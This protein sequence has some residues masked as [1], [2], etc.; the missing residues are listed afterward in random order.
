MKNG[1]KTTQMYKSNVSSQQNWAI[2]SKVLHLW[3]L[4]PRNTNL[5][6]ILGKQEKNPE[7]C[8]KYK[9]R[10][11]ASITQKPMATERS[12]NNKTNILETTLIQNYQG[13]YFC[14]LLSYHINN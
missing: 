13:L 4:F 14:K 12:S 1:R 9:P 2:C 8:V 5:F 6:L 11:R 3:Q 10:G 7:H